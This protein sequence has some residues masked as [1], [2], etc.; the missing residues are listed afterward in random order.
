MKIKRTLRL[1]ALALLIGMACILPVPITFTKKDN[2]PK[3]LIEQ[4]DTKEN[5]NEE[6]KDIKELF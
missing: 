4:I 1:I 2:F 3:H 5:D 6:E